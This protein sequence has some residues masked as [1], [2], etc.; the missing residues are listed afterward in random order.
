MSAA[1]LKSSVDPGPPRLLYN[2]SSLRKT[3]G[4]HAAL[5]KFLR[6]TSPPSKRVHIWSPPCTVQS[7]PFQPWSSYPAGALGYFPASG[8]TF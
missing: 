8:R 2:S 7:S 1:L 3:A 4:P 5:A 6:P